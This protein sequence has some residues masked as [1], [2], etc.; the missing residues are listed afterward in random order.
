MM[1]LLARRFAANPQ[2]HPGIDWNG[3]AAALTEEHLEKL[4][5]LEQCGGEPD[6]IGENEREFLLCE[7]CEQSPDRRSY[8][9]DQAALDGRRRNKPADSVMGY[10]ERCGF[11]LCDWETYCLLQ[12]RGEF[13]SRSSSWL[14]SPPEIRARGGAIFGEKR[15][16]TLWRYH[17]GAESYYSSRGFRCVLRVS[18]RRQ[19]VSA[20][21]SGF[22]G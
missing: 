1:D 3:L 12:S 15:Y 19:I 5:L 11:E 2:R 7:C 10:C 21:R 17:N 14:L 16:G 6:C 9:Y 22:E 13:D 8:C 4:R 18:K 20:Q